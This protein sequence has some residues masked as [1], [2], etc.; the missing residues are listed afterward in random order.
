MNKVSFKAAFKYPFNR[1]VGMWNILWALPILLT[2]ILFFGAFINNMFQIYFIIMSIL[3]LILGM[4]ITLAFMGYKI[5]IAQEFCNGKFEQLPTF[6]FGSDLKLGFFMFLKTIPLIVAYIVIIM[7]AEKIG[8]TV[9]S[10]VS[11]VIGFFMLPI[12]FMNFFNKQTVASLF[13]FKITSSVFNNLGDYFMVMLKSIGL[14]IVFLLMWI[15]LIGIPAGS[16]SKNIFL[17]D[18]YRRNVK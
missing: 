12:L 11:F 10:A 17:A 5:K 18:F 2:T 16:F 4:P 1:A 9:S 14:G 3:S 8:T 13:E 7:I 15:V 6:K